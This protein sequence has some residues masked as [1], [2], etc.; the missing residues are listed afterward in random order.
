AAL[1]DT[2]EGAAEADAAVTKLTGLPDAGRAP[3]F[4][5]YQQAAQGRSAAIVKTGRDQTCADLL[6]NLGVGS[7][8]KQ[9]IWVADGGM[10]L[11]D[12]ICGLA[13]HGHE[14]SSYAGA[15]MFSSTSTLKV[16]PLR[17]SLQTISM[18]KAEV[19]AGKS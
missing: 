18:H 8:A 3:A 9:E 14:V 12:F 19:R 17:D 6:S 11:G 16:T 7:D 5:A 4:R 13:E 2:M 10:P 15:G 1:P